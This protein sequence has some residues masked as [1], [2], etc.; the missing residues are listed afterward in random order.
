MFQV[1]DLLSL[2]I[3]CPYFKAGNSF[4]AKAP[5]NN[6][7]KN[8][9]LTTDCFHRPDFL[10]S[11]GFWLCLIF[12]CDDLNY[13]PYHEHGMK[14]YFGGSWFWY[15]EEL[16]V[17]EFSLSPFKF[18]M[19]WQGLPRLFCIRFFIGGLFQRQVSIWSVKAQ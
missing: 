11:R 10:I 19:I 14:W 2:F 8:Q 17:W 6:T 18:E 12:G 5:L 1:A 3:F 7:G 13:N 16:K 15:T 9:K 4:G